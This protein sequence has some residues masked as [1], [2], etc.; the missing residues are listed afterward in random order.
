MSRVAVAQ[1]PRRGRPDPMYRKLP[2]GRRGTNSLSKDEVARDQRRRLRGAMIE[3]VAVHGYAATTTRELSALAAVS[4]QDM[5]RR[6]PNKETYF[7]A[8]YDQIVRRTVERVELAYHAQGDW[9]AGLR[10]ALDTYIAEVVARPKAARLMLV[11]ALGAGPTALERMRSSR[12][13]FEHVLAA[14]F[15]AAPDGV[16]VSPLVVKGIVC[17]VERVT[18]QRLAGG[19]EELS[20][21][22]EGLSGISGELFAWALSYRD[23]AASRLGDPSRVWCGGSAPRRG[24][25]AEGTSER[26][27]VLRA[28]AR[29]A[30]EQGYSQLTL[31]QIIDAAGV[32]EETFRERYGDVERCFQGALSLLALE[33]FRCAER[34]AR[35]GGD[36]AAAVHRGT[37]ALVCHLARDPVLM[38]VAFVEVLA[39][40]PEAIECRE[41]LL[42]KFSEL[43]L[44]T[45]PESSRSSSVTAEAS[46]GAIWGVLEHCVARGST[47]LLAGLAVHASY[48][49]LAPAIGGEDAVGAILAGDGS[50]LPN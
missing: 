1:A 33:V 49:A 30:A 15:A 17:G 9:Q 40:G 31:G 4:K 42:L 29:L 26:V 50:S 34:A 44:K 2:R 48:L 12:R 32:P 20:A 24:P 16:V 41:S 5:Y 3:A 46:V 47:R 18:R 38:R 43:L 6:F 28:T 21:R 13:K 19:L 45:L 27:R 25:R 10:A 14:I 35:G 22:A 7:L 39:A 11:G 23:R 37:E 36:P 8:T